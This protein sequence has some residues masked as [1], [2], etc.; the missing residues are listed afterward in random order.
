MKMKQTEFIALSACTMTL[1]ALGIDIM[2]PAFG[3][4]REHFGLPPESTATAQIISFFFMGQIAQ[5]AF[6]ALS[7]RFG[8]LAILRIGFPLYITGGLAAAFSPSLQLMLAARF[9]AG[10][11]A[12]AV[13]MTTIAGVR[14][15]FVGDQMARIMS[16]IFTI[17]L[18]T[19]VL[20]PFLGLAILS[21]ASWKMVFLTPPLFAVIVFT[22]SLRLEES[23]PREQRTTLN[24]TDIGQSIRGVICNR[25][26]LRY[27]GVTTLLFTALSSYVA[28]SE[29]IVG[30]IYGKPELFAWIF[31]GM[32]LLMSLCALLNARLSSRFGAWRTIRWLLVIYTIVGALLLLYTFAAGDPPRMSLFFI[33][34]ALLMA[35]NL[36]VEPNSSALALEPM[37]NMA[38]MASAVYGTAFFFIGA[39]LGSVISHFMEKSVFPLVLSFFVIGLAAVLLVF[40][41][42]RMDRLKQPVK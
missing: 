20:A 31:A 35:I 32:G 11:G 12:S 25:I 18:F 13:F 29:H 3:A 23:L 36:A 39:S 14:D 8:R 37:G 40:S 26:F 19:P 16:L 15:R 9:I 17:F 1:T 41:D 4:L 34:I 30:E 42:L 2:L 28:S 27:T 6:G 24:W 5:I 38:G 10:M 22:W 7:D 21:V 33:A